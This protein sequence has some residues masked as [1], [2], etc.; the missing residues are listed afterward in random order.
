MPMTWHSG[1]VTL[2]AHLYRIDVGLISAAVIAYIGYWSEA[3]VGW[4]SKVQTGP[5]QDGHRLL[6]LDPTWI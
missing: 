4:T 3:E 2:T 6:M 5:S 1:A